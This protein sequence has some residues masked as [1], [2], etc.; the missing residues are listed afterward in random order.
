M[1]TRLV[2]GGGEEAGRLE[3][4]REGEEEWDP[5]LSP[6]NMSSSTSVEVMVHEGDGRGLGLIFPASS[7][8]GIWSAVPLTMI[9]ASASQNNSV[10]LVLSHRNDPSAVL[11]LSLDKCQHGQIKFQE[12][13]YAC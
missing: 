2:D 8:G 5:I 9:K 10:C 6:C 13:A 11:A 4:A 3:G 1:S 12:I 7:K